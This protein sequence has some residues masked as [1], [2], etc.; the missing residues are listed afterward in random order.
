MLL[1]EEGSDSSA[2]DDDDVD[3]DDIGVDSSTGNCLASTSQLIQLPDTQLQFHK[4]RDVNADRPAKVALCCVCIVVLDILWLMFAFAW[5]HKEFLLKDSFTEIL[6]S[7]LLVSA[8]T[9][10]CMKITDTVWLHVLY[11][12]IVIIKILML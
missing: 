12:I 6:L 4:C 5:L 9:M 7:L 2:A 8:G 10:R 11:W 3:D 1:S